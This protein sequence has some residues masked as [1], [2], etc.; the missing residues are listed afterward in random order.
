MGVRP[1]RLLKDGEHIEHI[2]RILWK[3]GKKGCGRCGCK[4]ILNSLKEGRNLIE[5]VFA[6]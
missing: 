3:G 6:F 2:D 1:I 5:N 4:M